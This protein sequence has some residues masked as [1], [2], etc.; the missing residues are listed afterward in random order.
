MCVCVCVWYNLLHT[1]Y[2]EY[3]EVYICVCMY[4]CVLCYIL[5]CVYGE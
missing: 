2:G 3:P 5:H 4:V 1:V